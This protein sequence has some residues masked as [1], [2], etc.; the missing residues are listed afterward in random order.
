MQP[1]V[2]I[3]QSHPLEE[4]KGFLNKDMAALTAEELKPSASQPAACMGNIHGWT[5]QNH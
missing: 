3:I 1:R 2:G 5:D 4:E